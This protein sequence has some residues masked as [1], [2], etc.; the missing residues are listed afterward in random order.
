MAKTDA[1]LLD[2]AK[3]AYE[4]VMTSGQAY[5]IDG[6]TYTRADL[7]SLQ[8]QISWLESKVAAAAGR[9]ARNLV[10]FKRPR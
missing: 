8:K 1:E 6:R 10:R 5:Q 9:S 4:K 2:I 7:D 3:E